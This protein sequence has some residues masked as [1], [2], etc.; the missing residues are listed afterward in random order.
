MEHP[1]TDK[2]LPENESNLVLSIMN[3]INE[4]YWHPLY[5]YLHENQGLVKTFSAFLLDYEQIVL[6]IGRT[7][8]GIEYFGKEQTSE[9]PKGRSVKVVHYDFT[10]SGTNLLE[11][12]I[13][14]KFSST[15][16][17]IT[18]PLPPFSEDL[19][20]PTNKGMD[21]LIELNW[22]WM[23]QDSFIGINTPMFHVEKGKFARMI[24]A[25]F[26]D[27]DENGLKTRH[28]KWLDLLPLQVEDETDEN[29]VIRVS[30]TELKSLIQH[31]A[32]YIYP[33]PPKEDFKFN[34]LPQIN[35]FVEIVGNTKTTEPELTKFLEQPENQFILT[36]GFLS[37]EIYSQ[38]LCSWQS[39]ERDGIQPDFFIVRP[40]GYADILEFKLPY[41]KGQIIVGKSNRETFSAELNSYISQTRVYKEY[42]EDPNNRNWVEQKYNIKV[43]YP[44]RILVVGRR[45]DFSSD[46]WKEII[47]DYKDIEIMTFDD[48]IDGVV[49]QFYM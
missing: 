47:D 20:Y 14:F 46:E 43:R 49:S 17:D 21:K 32:H 40:N 23:A 38:L 45:W 42:F 10:D 36:M 3:S 37:K 11:E 22:N 7:H 8:L 39:E 26:F 28:I 27:A 30:L 41:L 29:H 34:K 44:R 19:V 2:Q 33:L 16:M 13:G 48:L 24:N 6:Y 1:F 31:D 12:I 18:L 5:N 25:R 9:L 35:R 4:H 15:A